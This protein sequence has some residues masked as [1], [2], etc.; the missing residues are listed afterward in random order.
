MDK[1]GNSLAIEEIQR[2]TKE[3]PKTYIVKNGDTL[4]KIAKLQLNNGSRYKEIA[5]LNNISDVNKIYPGM[6]LKLQ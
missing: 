6:I 2:S 3:P 1:N 5:E 4:W